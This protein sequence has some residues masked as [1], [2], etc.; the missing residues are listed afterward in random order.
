MQLQEQE[1]LNEKREV[2]WF[3]DF[4]EDY[5][6]SKIPFTEFYKVF[7]VFDELLDEKTKENIVELVG[8]LHRNNYNLIETSQALYIH[9]NTLVFRLNRVKHC[10][11]I[12]PMKEE[13]DRAFLSYLNTFFIF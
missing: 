11:G 5:M 4:I 6:K 2:L 12:N 9:R 13:K 8:P 3:Y 1:A 7:N 10:L